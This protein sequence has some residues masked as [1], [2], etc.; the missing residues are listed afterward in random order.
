MQASLTV[1]TERL[2]ALDEKINTKLDALTAV[3]CRLMLCGEGD[4]ELYY[5]AYSFSRLKPR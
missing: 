1:T 2:H 5:S 4:I 3:E